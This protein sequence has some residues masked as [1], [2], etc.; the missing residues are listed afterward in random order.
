MNNI[1]KIEEIFNTIY[2]LFL[3]VLNFG[4]KYKPK[5]G[6]KQSLSFLKSLTLKIVQK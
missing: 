3:K 1:I 4:T 5:S 2:V 6:L